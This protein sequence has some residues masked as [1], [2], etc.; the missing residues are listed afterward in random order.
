MTEPLWKS[1]AGFCICVL[2]GFIVALGI[3]VIR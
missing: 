1:A 2:F 3:Y